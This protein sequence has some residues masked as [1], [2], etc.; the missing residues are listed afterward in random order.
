[1]S[2]IITGMQKLAR[3]SPKGQVV[4]PAKLRRRL[5]ISRT[6]MMRE[7]DGK[8]ILEPSISMEEAFGTGGNEMR[9]LAKRISR[10]RRK[11]VELERKKLSV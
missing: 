6:V 9:E 10:D 8:I 2:Y 3:V 1:M 4:I 11:E 7:E 5:K